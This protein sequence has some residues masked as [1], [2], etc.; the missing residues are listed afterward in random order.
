M[1]FVFYFTRTKYYLVYKIEVVIK[2]FVEDTNLMYIAASLPRKC[3]V[4]IYLYHMEMF[5][6]S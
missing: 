2:P 5:A 4:N 3:R 1:T 6:E